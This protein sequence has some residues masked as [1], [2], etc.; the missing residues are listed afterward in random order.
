MRLKTVFTALSLSAAL[1]VG[2]CGNDDGP[3]GETEKKDDTE[4]FWAVDA[5]PDTVADTG[6][7]DDAATKGD[8]RA[9]DPARYDQ[10][11]MEGCTAK[12]ISEQECKGYCPAGGKA[13]SGA[14]CYDACVKAGGKSAYCKTGCA[15]YEPCDKAGD[16]GVDCKAKCFDKK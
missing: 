13:G 15:C 7:A 8:G 5:G 1:S 4:A 10:K 12:G 2:G 16:K 11:C 14:S 6:S 9:P 3:A